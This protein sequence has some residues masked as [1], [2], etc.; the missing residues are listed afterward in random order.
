MGFYSRTRRII[1]CSWCGCDYLWGRLRIPQLAMLFKHEAGIC[2]HCS[3]Q[4]AHQMDR[5]QQGD[6]VAPSLITVRAE[7]K[8]RATG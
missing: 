3:T 8:V 2:N 6:S 5:C 4:L 1:R 7:N